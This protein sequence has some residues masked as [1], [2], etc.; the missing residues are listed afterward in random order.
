MYFRVFWTI[1]ALI[2]FGSVH[3]SYAQDAEATSSAPSDT[4][5]TEVQTA[6]GESAQGDPVETEVADKSETDKSEASEGKTQ[7]EAPKVAPPPPPQILQPYRNHVFF[8]FETSPSLDIGT[9]EFVAGDVVA[10]LQAM[11]NQMWIVNGEPSPSAFE[12]SQK[13]LESL[14]SDD[15][16]ELLLP[17]KLD[18]IF[19]ATISHEVGAYRVSVR[20]WDSNSRLLGSHHTQLVMERRQIAP[21]LAAEIAESFRPLAEMEDSELEETEFLIRAG[22]FPPQDPSVGQLKVGDYLTPYMRYLNR[23][24]EVQQI[25]PIPWTYLRVEEIT[26]SRIRVSVHS[27]FRNPIGAAR[28]RVEVMALAIKPHLANTE[29]KIYPRNEKSNP[30][31]GVRCE[32]MNRLPTAEDTVEDR[33]EMYTDRRGIVTVP[34]QR[35]NPLQYLLVKS[36]QALLARVPFIPGDQ[37][38]LE[39]EV[40]ND[41]A[42]LRVEGEVSLLQSQLIDIVATREVLMARSRAAA[43]KGEWEKVD[44]FMKQLEELPTYENYL[45]QVETLQVQA[46]Y[47]AQL[48]RDRVAEKRI[49]DL[50]TKILESSEKHLDARRIEEFKREMNLERGT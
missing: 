3:F 36:G 11:F 20:E 8:T 5:Q 29:L 39:V 45:S 6:K 22:E 18:K 13:Q 47:Q 32:V 24:R 44:T 33:L 41:A 10:R 1:L 4:D 15:V 27:A 43:K 23:Q 37:P 21:T 16:T 42:R 14:T 31:V 46:V 40:P 2:A 48:A 50:C 12:F 19:L 35:D 28:R 26:R 49:K 38:F 34:V 30:I 7:A 25:Q 17:L 9:R